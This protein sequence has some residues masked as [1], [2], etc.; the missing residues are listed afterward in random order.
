MAVRNFD[1]ISQIG[2][3][4]REEARV[5]TDLKREK[6]NLIVNRIR[7]HRQDCIDAIDTINHLS[8]NG[9]FPAFKEWNKS[10]PIWVRDG[11]IGI[12]YY[13][14]VTEEERGK[15]TISIGYIPT[16]DNLYFAWGGYGMGEC[17]KD[18][19]DDYIFN[20]VWEKRYYK[21]GLEK[22]AISL[23]CWLKNFFEWVDQL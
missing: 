2:N 1:K 7:S 17:Y 16:T 19:G 21:D 10:T 11:K 6:F 15:V 20:N 13:D 23:E 8:K 9:L 5:A 12:G 22:F 18:V 14:K 4:K 3:Q